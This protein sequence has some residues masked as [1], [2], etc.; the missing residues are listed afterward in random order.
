MKLSAVS[1]SATVPTKTLTTVLLYEGQLP[2]E[3]ED[4]RKPIKWYSPPHRPGWPPPYPLIFPGSMPWRFISA[5]SSS[6]LG[7]S[8]PDHSACN[9]SK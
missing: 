6:G 1:L 7:G 3:K 4:G 8:C 5:P 2:E 9:S